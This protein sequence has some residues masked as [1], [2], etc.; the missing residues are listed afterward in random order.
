MIR[1]ALL[2]ACALGA[3]AAAPAAWAQ[4][5][6]ATKP[7]Q[8]EERPPGAEP[9]LEIRQIRTGMAFR[10]L[11]QAQFESKL[12]EQDVLNVQETYNVTR[13]RA[14]ALKIELDKALKA[15]EV[16]KAKEAAARKRYDEALQATSR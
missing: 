11:Q 7:S 16:A 9:T 12:A 6:P 4:A 5:K 2:I 13:G 1:R 15:R 3:W 14:E 8:V 10:E